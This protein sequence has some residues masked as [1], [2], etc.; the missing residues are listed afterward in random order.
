M[1]E[2]CPHSEL[3][4]SVFSRIWTEYRDMRYLSVFS[5]NAE[6]TDQKNSKWGH[7]SSS[8]TDTFSQWQ[9]RPFTG[10]LLEV[11]LKLVVNENCSEGKAGLKTFIDYALFRKARTHLSLKEYVLFN[12]LWGKCKLLGNDMRIYYISYIWNW[13]HLLSRCE[14]T[15]PLKHWCW[16]D[17]WRNIVHFNF[18][19]VW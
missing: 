16:I 11:V 14:I 17:F 13:K 8:D 7:F 15:V 18:N 2:R 9:I 10:K 1:R 12:L 19:L 5:H 4:W 3:F 6:N